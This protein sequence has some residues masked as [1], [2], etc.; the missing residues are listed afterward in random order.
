MQISCDQVNAL[1]EDEYTLTRADNHLMET[2]PFAS[3]VSPG[4]RTW[5]EVWKSITEG[6]WSP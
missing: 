4:A 2:R 6:P 5:R 3:N 1:R